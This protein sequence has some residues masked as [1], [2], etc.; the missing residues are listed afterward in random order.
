MVMAH[1]RCTESTYSRSAAY[2]ASANSPALNSEL[3]IIRSGIGFIGS[4]LRKLKIA[5]LRLIIFG[6]IASQRGRSCK[7]YAKS[8]D[9][10]KLSTTE[11]PRFFI[12]VLTHDEMH[13]TGLDPIVDATIEQTLSCGQNPARPNHGP[14][15]ELWGSASDNIDATYCNPRPSIRRDLHPLVFFAENSRGR[16]RVGTLAESGSEQCANNR[17]QW[18]EDIY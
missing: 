2:P 5:Q 15:A 16:I 13:G 1:P 4:S 6:S 12:F 9:W 17:E 7:R 8:G 14:G 18:K 11:W 3:V 10:R